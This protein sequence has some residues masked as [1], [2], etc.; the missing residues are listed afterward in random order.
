MGDDPFK[1]RLV[2]L[3]TVDPE[4]DA[5]TLARWCEDSEYLRLADADPAILYSPS[6]QTEFFKQEIGECLLFAIRTLEDD[7]L[8]GTLDFAHVNQVSGNTWL[9][10]GIGERDY[11]NHGY[12]SDA[13][14]VLLRYGFWQLNL[15]RV[16]LNVFDY[17]SRAIRSYE[18]LGFRVEGRSRGWLL[19]G[20]RRWDLVYMGLLRCEWEEIEARITEE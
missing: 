10:I 6:Q 1:G 19:R 15:H 11:W 14:C 7:R 20:G 16:S 2:R 17:N 8:I 13:M 5:A 9:G 12:G 18:K 3:A 4:K